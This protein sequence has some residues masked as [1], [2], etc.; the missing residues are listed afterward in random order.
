M[1]FDAD[2]QKAIDA[3]CD[4]GRRVIAITGEAGSG[5][6]TIMKY[7]YE[8]LTGNGLNVAMAAPTGKA[9]RRIREAT[10]IP[11][12]TIHKLLK[13]NRP[14]YDLET[15]E[16]TGPTEPGVGKNNPLMFDAVLVDEY[17]MVS[18]ELHR[19][20]IDALK[21]GSKICIFGDINQLPPIEQ[22]ELQRTTTAF[23]TVLSLPNAVTLTSVHRQ[24]EGSSILVNAHRIRRGAFPVRRDTFQ[25]KIT[26]EPVKELIKHIDTEIGRGIDYRKIENQILTPAAKTWL[27]THAL[28]STIQAIYYDTAD[29]DLDGLLLPRHK[30]DKDRVV[31]IHI[32]EKVICT[33]NTYD[34][35]NYEERFSVVDPDTGVGLPSNFIEA[36]EQFSM[37]NG[38]TGVVLAIDPDGGFEVDFGD[39][40]VRVPPYVLE[41]IPKLKIM[42]KM[43]VR[44]R[45]DLAYV[46]TTHKAQGSEFQ[47][48]TYLMNRSM[49]YNQS[50]NNFYT[51][52]TRARDSC[53]LITDQDS[54]LDSIKNTA[55]VKEKQL[56][57]YK[58]HK[59]EQKRTEKEDEIRIAANIAKI[60]KAK[61]DRE[62]EN[63]AEAKTR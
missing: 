24:A 20:L 61:Y 33:E 31:E 50:R 10:G 32:G 47:N 13:Y 29:P 58:K 11:A 59:Q 2:Q 35:R 30:W 19:N 16:A 34:L 3:C 23:E 51:A 9:A 54:L 8:R 26:D 60:Q 21:P 28:N 56:V 45:I 40:V 15:G 37:L 55:A 22:F 38:E 44:R 1:N 48:V 12:I 52:V 41:Y 5:K 7:V 49:Y 4:P 57:A 27:G 63:Q 42:V 43:D 46:I 53:Y 62:A 25:F 17:A 18:Q 6:T 39:R 14:D 36:P